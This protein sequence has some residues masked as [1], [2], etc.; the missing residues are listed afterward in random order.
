MYIRTPICSMCD[1]IEG[2]N[3]QYLNV[4]YTSAYSYCIL[5]SIFWYY[6]QNSANL[7]TGR[8]HNIIINYK[9]IECSNGA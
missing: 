7:S 8:A 9:L 5:K 1:S 3:D 6:I 2:D 4:C